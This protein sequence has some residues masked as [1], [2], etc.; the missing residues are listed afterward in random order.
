M[1]SNREKLTWAFVIVVA[2]GVLL[3]VIFG[4]PRTVQGSTGGDSWRNVIYDFQTLITGLAAVFAAAITIRTMEKTDRRSERRHRELVELQL[5]PDR[6]RLGRALHPQIAELKHMTIIISDYH[7]LRDELRGGGPR[8]DWHWM[9]EVAKRFLP[10]FDDVNEILARR[11][12]Q[13][14]IGLLDG[15]TTRLL[16][17]LIQNYQAASAALIRHREVASNPREHLSY[18]QDFQTTFYHARNACNA[19]VALLPRLI[20]SLEHVESKYA[21]MGK[22]GLFHIH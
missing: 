8:I 19:F 15:E 16:D 6:L 22:W 1:K 10:W 4:E 5:R 14:G 13:D 9:T 17:L 11:Q 3:P 21:V 7:K 20:D 2:A 12:F 18:E